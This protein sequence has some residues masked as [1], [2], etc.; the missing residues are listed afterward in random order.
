MTDHVDLFLLRRAVHLMQECAHVDA[1]DEMDNLAMAINAL[2]F[3]MGNKTRHSYDWP[4]TGL[5]EAIDYAA[6]QCSAE[7]GI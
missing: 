1:L 3:D 4:R 5:K 7:K 2:L 6:S